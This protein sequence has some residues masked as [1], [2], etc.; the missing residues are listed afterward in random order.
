MMPGIMVRVRSG[1][2]L[3]LIVLLL[4]FFSHPV[5][6][7]FLHNSEELKKSINRFA[8]L[9]TPPPIFAE[10][11]R[12]LELDTS[13]FRLLMKRLEDRER[14]YFLQMRPFLH[15]LAKASQKTG[16][17][18]SSLASFAKRESQFNPQAVSNKGAYGLMGVTIQAYQDVVR[19]RDREKWIDEALAE[20]KDFSWEDVKTNSELNVV[21]GAIYYKFLLEKFKNP[22]LAS[23]AYNW[24]MGNVYIMQNRYG[25]TRDILSRLKKLASWNSIWEE[26]AKYPGYILEFESVFQKINDKIKKVYAIERGLYQENFALSLPS[27]ETPSS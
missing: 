27:K 11:Y 8:A 12:Y 23:L 17:P 2:Y 1:K 13:S 20:Y 21:V 14:V 24:G 7:P 15:E 18:L 10:Y 3:I 19:L 5:N 26:P 22:T 9:Y 25:N 4:L 16:I 6:T